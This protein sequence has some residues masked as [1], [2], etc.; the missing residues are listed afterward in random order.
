MAGWHSSKISKIEHGRQ[1]PSIED[2]QAWCEYCGVPGQASDLIATLH[3]VEGMFVE[4]P[5]LERTGLRRAQE[6]A[7]PLFE[8][9]RHFRAYD[10]WLVPGLLQTAPYTTA[11]LEAVAAR[12]DIR[13]DIA[14]AVAVRMQRQ[15]VLYEGDRRFA[16]LIEEPVLRSRIGG[17]DTMIG[18]LAHLLTVGSLPSTSLGVIPMTADRDLR[19][20]EGFWIFDNER[21]NVELVSGWL[22]LTR[23]REVAT[24]V[25]VF[26]RLS[27]LAVFGGKARGLITAAI[28]AL[29]G[30]SQA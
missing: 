6:M 12:R 8:R 1:T 9:T 3:V 13:E 14:A 10:S 25:D 17:I 18:Q 16:I 29:D 24:Y 5:R 22:T 2:I 11:L 15:R 27:E 23:P 20:V 30:P 28:D 7:S 19:P 26:A 21:V 4:W